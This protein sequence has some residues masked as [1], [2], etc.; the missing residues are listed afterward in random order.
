MS[1]G[2]TSWEA[3]KTQNR[4]LAE[5]YL[6]SLRVVRRLATATLDSY[7][8]DLTALRAFAS[9]QGQSLEKLAHGDLDA[10]VHV[11]MKRGLSPRSVARVVACVRGFY[12]SLVLGRRVSVNPAEDLRAP[13]SWP[14]L[15]KRLSEEEIGLLIAQPDTSTAQGLRDRA[16]GAA[17]L[18]QG[19]HRL[20]RL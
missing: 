17:R 3:V 15:P 18:P 9:S 16:G 10:F 5:E 8:R 11:L 13:K 1:L 19:L 14:A 2:K 6:D 4:F 20:C 12:R 7:S